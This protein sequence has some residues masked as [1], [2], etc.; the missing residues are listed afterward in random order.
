MVVEYDTPPRPSV[1]QITP[2]GFSLRHGR[3]NELAAIG[4][5]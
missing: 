1:K 2:P 4:F 5:G 3:W